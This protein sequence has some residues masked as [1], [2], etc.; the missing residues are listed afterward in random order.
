MMN[1]IINVL[2]H[3]MSLSDMNL[4]GFQWALFDAYNGKATDATI[5]KVIGVGIDSYNYD[6]ALGEHRVIMCILTEESS[7]E[8]CSE[9]F[10]WRDPY[11]LRDVSSPELEDFS[12]SHG[13]ILPFDHPVMEKLIM[14]I[15]M[16]EL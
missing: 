14:R 3:L 2:E 8:I 1:N 9:Q 6:K 12:E 13:K 4:H 7:F 15:K 5:A 16:E 10:R 11:D